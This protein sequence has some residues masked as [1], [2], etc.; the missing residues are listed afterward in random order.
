MCFVCQALAA[1]ANVAPYI[2]G[3]AVSEGP[4]FP[5]ETW[6]ATFDVDTSICGDDAVFSVVTMLSESRV[7]YMFALLCFFVCCFFRG[8]VLSVHVVSDRCCQEES[9]HSSRALIYGCVLFFF[10]CSA[11][12]CHGVLFFYVASR[13]VW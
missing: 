4:L 12:P 7:V 8:F 5:G 6:R 13:L 11:A 1:T 9:Y 3:A 2:C 10:F